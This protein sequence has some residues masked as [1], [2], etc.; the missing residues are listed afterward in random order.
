MSHNSP[1]GPEAA[2]PVLFAAPDLSDD[3][4][5][6]V[7]RVLRSG[8][9]T[10]GGECRALEE[11]LAD[12]LGA[13]EVVAMSSCTAALEAAVAHLDLPP[14]SRVGVPTWTFVSTALSAVHSGHVP[15]LLDVE[16]DTLN[17]SV[18]SLE[19]ALDG[20]DGLDAVI[21][22]HFGGVAFGKQIHELC[23][24]HAVPLIED[25]AHALG[26]S[27][28]RGPIT[29]QGTAGA[30]LSFYATK[31]LT[32]AEGGALVTDD[33]ELADFARSYRLHG[34][35]RDAWARYRPGQRSGYDVVTPGIKGNLPDVLAAL[36]LSQLDRFED[37]QGRR[38]VLVNHYRDALAGIDGLTCVPGELD[39]YGADHLMAVLLPEGTDRDLVTDRMTARG[40]STSVHF[41]PLH[42]FDWFAANAEIG[43]SGVETATHQA[44]RELS[45]PL[46][47]GLTVAQVDRVVAALVEGLEQVRSAA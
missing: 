15:V 23:T 17:L 44:P 3:D 2:E 13:S 36:A 28:H 26:T 30:C 41:Q 33:P 5:D 46:H 22:V 11:A 47:P 9:I 38:R 14:G 21:G 4:V 18:D 12:H 45:L 16:P 35:S 8:W 19:A 31:N 42:R 40:V 27:D 24:E 10:T 20:P 34:L 32:S 37:M 39:P 1:D 43:P 25:A 6:A 29:G 7:V